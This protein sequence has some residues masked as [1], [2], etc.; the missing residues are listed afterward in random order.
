MRGQRHVP[1]ALYPQERP[2][3]H[4]TGGWVG[5][6]AGLDRCGKSRPRPGFDPRAVQPVAQ[7]LYRLRYRAHG[8]ISTTNKC[9]QL[10]GAPYFSVCVCVGGVFFL[11]FFPFFLFTF[12]FFLCLSFSLS[13]QFVNQSFSVDVSQSLDRT[14]WKCWPLLGHP[15]CSASTNTR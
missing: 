5:P 8:D 1:A 2:G 6:R 10:R 4:C 7:S 15:L 12:F 9:H 11:S 13:S 3:T 14:D